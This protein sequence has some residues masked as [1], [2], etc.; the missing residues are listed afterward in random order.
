MALSREEV[1]E[2]V[3]RH[4]WYH[5][6]DLG[7]GVV[8]P[9][10]GWHF[11]W[12]PS[13]E[14]LKRVDFRGKTV[15]EIGTWDGYFSFKVEALGAARVIATDI[16]LWETFLL[17][18]DILNSK[19][20]FKSASI[21]TLDEC[22]P[23]TPFDV[24]VCYGIYYHL[25]FPNLALTKMN[26]VL[27]PG[28]ILLLE[29]AYYREHEDKSFLYFS[30]G[31]D[32]LVPGDPTYCTCPTLKC[33]RNM[34]HASLFEV[35]EVLPYHKEGKTGRVLVE[36]RRR[37]KNENDQLYEHGYPESLLGKLG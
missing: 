10:R 37:E 12:D 31:A 14:F 11:I 22:F 7:N 6:I 17:A 18:R 30:Y 9:G 36:A 28:G 25:L 35:S 15:L 4:T 24:I 27:R 2:L 26:R 20:E 21:Y 5:N 32:R 23:D 34:L 13:A 33:L 1:L 8:T 19:V 16:K 3:N 29:G